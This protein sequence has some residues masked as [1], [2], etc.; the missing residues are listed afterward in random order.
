[1]ENKY[2][3]EQVEDIKAREKKALAYL[4][5]LELTPA[6]QIVKQNI[7]DDVFGDRLYPYLADIKYTPHA[8]GVISPFNEPDKKA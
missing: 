8:G 4:K 1:M 7:G 2:T 3:P 5:E 6:C